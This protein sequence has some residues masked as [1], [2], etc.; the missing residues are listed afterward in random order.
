M[1]LFLS[2]VSAYRSFPSSEA[3]HC[4]L[5]QTYQVISLRLTVGAVHRYTS[6]QCDDFCQAKRAFFHILSDIEPPLALCSRLLDSKAEGYFIFSKRT[7]RWKQYEQ[8]QSQQQQQEK[9]E[10]NKDNII[11]RVLN[12]NAEWHTVFPLS[13]LV[14]GL[15]LDPTAFE[16]ELSSGLVD[17]SA[18]YQSAGELVQQKAEWTD[19][20]DYRYIILRAKYALDIRTQQERTQVYVLSFHDITVTSGVESVLLLSQLIASRSD[21]SKHHILAMT[22]HELRTPLTAIIGYS[23]LL[24]EKYAQRLDEEGKEYLQVQ[25]EHYSSGVDIYMHPVLTPSSFVSVV[26]LVL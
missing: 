12:V 5:W 4:G 7:K 16:Q 10:D 22:S 26:L 3:G 9:Q 14:P 23:D 21:I 25:K 17:L 8:Y 13:T 19:D 20:G 24:I 6:R 1:F 11:Y 18:L 15:D 2:L